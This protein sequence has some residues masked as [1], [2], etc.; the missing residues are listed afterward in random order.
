MIALMFLTENIIFHAYKV[1]SLNYYTSLDFFF[2]R[3]IEVLEALTQTEMIE[4]T[5]KE[6]TALEC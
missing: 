4:G 3:V 2:I 6:C 1:H 5:Q